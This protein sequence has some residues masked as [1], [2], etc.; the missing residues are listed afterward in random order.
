[1]TGDAGCR[2]WARVMGAGCKVLGIHR[3]T[4]FPTEKGKVLVKTPWSRV[5]VFLSSCDN[6]MAANWN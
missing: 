4:K 1:M 3:R 6:S 2:V 5:R